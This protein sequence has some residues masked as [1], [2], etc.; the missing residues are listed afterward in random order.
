MWSAAA[1]DDPAL[2]FEIPDGAKSLSERDDGLGATKRWVRKLRISFGAPRQRD[3]PGLALSSR[4]S[5]A[6]SSAVRLIRQP[7]RSPYNLARR[8]AP[9][10]QV[11]DRIHCRI[12]VNQRR[13]EKRPPEREAVGVH[14]AAA[15]KDRHRRGAGAHVDQRGS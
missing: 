5:V 9:L 10:L 3:S 11:Q 1:W 4:R 12:H 2:G 7:A 13:V 14:E 6:A 8:R 15:G